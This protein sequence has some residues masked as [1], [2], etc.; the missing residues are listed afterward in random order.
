MLLFFFS[1]K[2]E[3]VELYSGVLPELHVQ[4]EC[5]CPPS[6]PRVH[7]LVE[8]YSITT[9]HADNTEFVW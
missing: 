4:S 6:H 5:R 8:R 9:S 3:I 7:P 1:L 2:R